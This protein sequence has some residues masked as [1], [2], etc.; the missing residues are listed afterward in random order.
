MESR[1]C[2]KRSPPFRFNC[3]P[4]SCLNV[5][6]ICLII[7]TQQHLFEKQ[8]SLSMSGAVR[9]HPSLTYF[10]TFLRETFSV[11][12]NNGLQHGKQC[13]VPCHSVRTIQN[14]T[15]TFR[16]IFIAP[17]LQVS[18][19]Y[20]IIDLKQSSIGEDDSW[21][22]FS[23]SASVRLT[24]LRKFHGSFLFSILICWRC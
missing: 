9:A 5:P 22:I 2:H 17:N 3:W 7:M 8:S 24:M 11:Q 1:G 4:A 23:L 18:L 21:K 20:D 16:R 14:H 19:V 13:F 15:V 6:T 10:G 12:K